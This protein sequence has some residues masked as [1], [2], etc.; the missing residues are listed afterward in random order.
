MTDDRLRQ[1]YARAL[2]D[3]APPAAPGATCDVDPEALLALA[4]G[5]L[6]EEDR[7]ALFDRVMASESCRREFALVRAAVVADATV[8]GRAPVSASAETDPAA[9]AAPAEEG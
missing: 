7:L 8:E 2:G 5:E 1:L 6:P 9:P 3:A 4:R